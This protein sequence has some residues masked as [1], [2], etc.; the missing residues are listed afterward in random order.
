MVLLQ[1]AMGFG[2]LISAILWILFFVGIPILAL[3]IF[4]LMKKESKNSLNEN[5]KEYRFKNRA[6]TILVSF[7]YAFL[8]III[9]T[10]LLFI[11]LM[12]W[13]PILD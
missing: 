10:V 7:L 2:L 6:S 13:N 8:A 11:T 9:L 5:V 4:G 1:G 12:A 3:F